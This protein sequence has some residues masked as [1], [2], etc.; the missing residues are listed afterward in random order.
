[1]TKNF[2]RASGEAKQIDKGGSGRKVVVSSGVSHG[3]QE[4]VLPGENEPGFAMRERSH[5]SVVRALWAGCGFLAFGLGALGVVVPVLPTFPFL[6]GAAFCF[7]RSSRRID[8][9]F[10]STVLFRKVLGGYVSGRAMTIRSKFMILIPVTLL[11]GVSFVLMSGIVV[12]RVVVG[13]I[14][15][16]HVV[17]FGFVVKTERSQVAS[18]AIEVPVAPQSAAADAES[19]R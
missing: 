7:A 14:W 13:A 2:K 16:A 18:S 4:R 10:R 1:M 8:A 12:G 6:L 3:K 17:Y 15:A 11:L 9:W 19:L 5:L